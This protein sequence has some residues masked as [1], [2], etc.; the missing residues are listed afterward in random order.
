MPTPVSHRW[1][2]LAWYA[3]LAVAA[4][5]AWRLIARLIEIARERWSS[6]RSM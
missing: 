5:V 2:Q 6:R 1:K 3:A 4:V